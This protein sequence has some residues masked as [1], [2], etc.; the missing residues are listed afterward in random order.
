MHDVDESI[1]FS[2]SAAGEAF[3]GKPHLFLVVV[4][5]ASLAAVEVSLIGGTDLPH[6]KRYAAALLLFNVSFQKWQKTNAGKTY[7][8][9]V[10]AYHQIMQEKKQCKSTIGRQFEYNTYI[11]A[12]FEDNPGK[13]LVDATKCWN[14]KKSLKGHNQYERADLIA[15]EE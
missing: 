6:R 3:N 2:R 7:G 10:A 9:A 14:Y 12:F 5:G 15:L 11:R 4:C 13:S 8:D 1:G